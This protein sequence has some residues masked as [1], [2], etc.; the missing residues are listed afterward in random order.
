[1]ETRQLLKHHIPTLFDELQRL[2]LPLP[3]D[4]QLNPIKI[5]HD[6][7]LADYVFNLT[8]QHAHWH[9]MR[10]GKLQRRQLGKGGAKRHRTIL[11]N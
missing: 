4:F 5:G 11:P 7:A 6:I 10:Y 8:F 2:I 9:V 1:M 3:T